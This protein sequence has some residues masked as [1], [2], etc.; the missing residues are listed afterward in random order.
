MNRYMK[1]HFQYRELCDVSTY[2]ANSTFNFTAENRIF[3]TKCAICYVTNRD[4]IVRMSSKD[5]YDQFGTCFTTNVLGG[6]ISKN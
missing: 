5:S 6:K 1:S 2:V 4:V 3:S